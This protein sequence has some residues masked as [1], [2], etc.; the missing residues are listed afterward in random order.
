MSLVQVHY[1]ESPASSYVKA[2]VQ[3]VQDIH[4]EGL[5]GD[6][7]VFLTGKFV[8]LRVLFRVQVRGLRVRSA[9]CFPGHRVYPKP[10]SVRLRQPFRD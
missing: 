1:L 10:L 8:G 2:A 3:T 4:R 7:L 6:I 5:P 9:L